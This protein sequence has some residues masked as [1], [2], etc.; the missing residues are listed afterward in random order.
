MWAIDNVYIGPSCLKFCSG[1]GQCTRNGCKCDPGFSG[2]ACELASQT[3]PAFV[4]E[5]FLSPRLSSYHN[6]QSIRGAEVS[7]GCGV[8]ASGKA[9]VFSK[10]GRRHL[11]TSFLDSTQAR[12]LQFTL[13]LSS[14][15]KLSTCKAPDQAGEG[16]LLH[17]SFDNGITWKLL[18]HFSYRGF[19]EPRIVSVQLPDEAKKFGVQFRWWQPYHSGRGHDVCSG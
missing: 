12:Y 6:F 19:Y 5:S 9:L 14:R 3:F 13:R 11:V 1:R 17:F 15:S 4:S 2:P 18:Q 16:V 8:L 10:D 7:F